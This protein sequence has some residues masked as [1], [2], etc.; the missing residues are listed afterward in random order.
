MVLISAPL[1][2]FSFI[3]AVRLYAQSS[4]NAAR[5]PQL[6]G[7]LS[8]LDGIIVPTFGAVYLMNTF[9]LP[10][11][12][13]RLIG[14]EKQ[15]GALKL[16]LQLPISINRLVAVKLAAL[17]VGWAIAL[18][19]TLSA[20]AIWGLLLGGHLYWPELLT[21]LLGHALYAFVIAGVAFLAAAV[22]D[23]SATA[24]IVA[25]SFTLG[26]W[27]LEFAGTTGSGLVRAIA[28]FSLSP[29][30]RGL[31]RG[32]LGSPTALTLLVLGLGFLG[33]S[34]VWLPP[35]VSRRQKLVRTGAVVGVAAQALLLAIQ[36]P[37]YV[38]VSENRRNSF[39]AADTRELRKMPK[40]LK[41]NVNLAANDSRLTDLDRNVLS[42]LQ[43]SMPHVTITYAETNSSSLFGGT[44][45]ANYGLV[46]YTYGGKEGISRAT[47][48]REVLPLIEALDGRI[49]I[50]DPVAVY[51]GYP[52]VSSAD[53]ASVWFYA[54]LPVM[55]IAGWWYCQRA[56]SV[57]LG[58]GGTPVPQV[59]RLSWLRRVGLA[60]GAAFFAIQLVPYGRSHTNLLVAAPTSGPVLAAAAQNCPTTFPP[61][62]ESALTLGAFRTQVAGMLNGLDSVIGGLAANTGQALVSQYGQFTVAYAGVSKEVAELYPCAASGLIADRL[63]ADAA[64]L[65]A[66]PPNLAAAGPPVTALRAGLASLATELNSRIQQASPDALVGNQDPAA[67]GAPSSTGVPAWDSERTSALV[68]RSCAACH[69]NQPGWSWS[70]NVAPLSWLVQHDVDAG[71]AVLNFSEWDRPQPAAAQAA[72]SVLSGRMPPAGAGVLNSDLRLTDAERADLARGLEATM[73]SP[74]T[75]IAVGT[76][77]GGSAQPGSAVILATLGTALAAIGFALGRSRR[78]ATYAS[79]LALALIPLGRPAP[80]SAQ[81]ATPM[82]ETFTEEKLGAAPTSFSTPT[83]FWS[84]GTAG[85]ADNK[86][87]LFEDGTQWSGSQTAN[88]LANQA[89]SL[90][91]DRWAEFIDDLPGTGYFPIAL[92]NQVPSFTGGTITARV[93][94]VGGDVDQDAGVLFNYQ[95]NGDM[96]ALRI[97]AQENNMILTQWVQGQPSQ[98]KL[99]AN[100]PAALSRWHD[101]VVTV[102]NGGTHLA[103]S[104]DGFKF[105]ETDLDTPVSGQVGVWS[106]SDT[107]ALFDSFSVDPNAQ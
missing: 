36:L 33:L 85:G 62:T 63:E 49:V 43:R 7:N 60:T 39:N 84:I 32:L 97:D 65:I 103:G 72:A 66:R 106:K 4:A 104:L 69:T 79:L 53:V 83:G 22:T 47:T 73:S 1:V 87:V 86:P 68:T 94:V 41:V 5:L 24:A 57:P 75:A 70:A 17:G 3:Q 51:P 107:V 28:S 38:D 61:G 31:E 102:S 2:G 76:P 42:K 92:F 48:A 10:F 6:A 88:A 98:L 105:L 101:V 40:E 96:M 9:L 14:N 11:V 19:P 18:V 100:V 46:T 54:L 15:T 52:L 81:T 99:I 64:L 59:T 90:Y 45:G 29:A 34:V 95:P 21:V 13:I 16:V 78:A 93:A 44:S 12:A 8:P 35:G 71:R 23:S 27:I 80:A 25:L 55:A 30:L 58:V 56:P 89:K 37:L 20:L 77:G 26:S 67:G 50:Q 82:V 91:G 74:N